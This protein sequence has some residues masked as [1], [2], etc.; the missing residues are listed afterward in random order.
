METTSAGYVEERRVTSSVEP[1]GY[2]TIN[3]DVADDGIQPASIELP[4]GQ[5]V[6]LVMRNRGRS[7]HHFHVSGLVPKDMLW[8]SKESGDAETVGMDPAEHSEHNHGGVMAPYHKCA[9][10]SSICPTGESVHV[11]AEAGGLDAILFTTT[12]TGT[13]LATDPLHPDMIAKVT[14]F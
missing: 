8:F 9:P 10:G 11:H 12:N 5:R 2:L 13:F 3:V 1:V 7:E 4:A 14:V 6:M